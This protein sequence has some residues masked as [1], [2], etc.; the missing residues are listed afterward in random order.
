MVIAIQK[1]NFVN[2]FLNA[3]ILGCEAHFGVLVYDTYVW[4]FFSILELHFLVKFENG[5]MF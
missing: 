1:L 5:L 3:C 4:F 2:I